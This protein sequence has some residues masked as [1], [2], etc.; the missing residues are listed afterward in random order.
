MPLRIGLGVFLFQDLP[1]KT[2]R[3]VCKMPGRSYELRHETVVKNARMT[4]PA[5]G[6]CQ[7][8]VPAN[9]RSGDDADLFASITSLTSQDGAA[10]EFQLSMAADGTKAT[11]Q[12]K[13]FLV[14][15]GEYTIQVQRF[16]D[17]HA[18]ESERHVVGGPKRLLVSAGVLTRCRLER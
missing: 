3:F 16:G 8:V 9:W 4:L 10:V 14:P 6:R 17:A 7:I 12:T 11:L 15:P 5:M 13:E 2:V 18:G 1:P